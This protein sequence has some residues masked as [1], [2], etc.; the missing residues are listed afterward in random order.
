MRGAVSLAAALALPVD[1]PERDLILFL[2]FAVILVTLVFQ[3]LTLPP[4]IRALGVHGDDSEEHEELVA[5]VAAANAALARIDELAQEDWTRDDTVERMRGLYS[6]RRRRFE[7]R[8]DG[9]GELDE[10]SSAYQRMVREVLAAQRGALLQLRNERV[11]SDEVMRRVE[12]EID[13]ED[14]RLEI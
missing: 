6:F 14:T 12:R 1:F 13:L 9:N 5:R 11:I 8:R 2:A 10:R 4:L 3:G 7:S